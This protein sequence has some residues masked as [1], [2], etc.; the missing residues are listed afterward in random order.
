MFKT[1]FSAID[2]RFEPWNFITSLK[3]MLVGMIGIFAIIGL[4]MIVTSLLNKI[5]GKKK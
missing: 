4:I 1:L 3:Y 2:F 5:K